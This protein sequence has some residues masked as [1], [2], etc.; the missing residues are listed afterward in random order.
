MASFQGLSVRSTVLVHFT[1]EE[2]KTPNRWSDLVSGTKW[3][4]LK[5]NPDHLTYDIIKKSSASIRTAVPESYKS[6]MSSLYWNA[7]S[8]NQKMAP[9]LSQI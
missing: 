6:I 9:A 5:V 3:W 2:T 8:K 7:S 1:N 4:N